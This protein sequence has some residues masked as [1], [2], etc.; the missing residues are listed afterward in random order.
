ME[1]GEWLDYLKE[2]GV[3][4]NTR[5]I[6]VSDHG[7]GLEQLDD[8]YIDSIDYDAM[9]LNPLFM[10]KD[11]NATGFTTSDEFMTN[12]DVPYL[13]AEG[14]IDNLVNPYTGKEISI[15]Q[16]EGKQKVVHS[17]KV[18]VDENNGFR[19][20]TSDGRWFTV[21]DNIFDPDNWEEIE[22]PK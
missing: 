16:K 12:A 17:H 21:H 11:F 1:V 13:A 6:L 22:E 9:W 19:F 20:D 10:V 5:I 2:M 3:Y 14:L 7:S 4:D 8:L 18:H 15:T